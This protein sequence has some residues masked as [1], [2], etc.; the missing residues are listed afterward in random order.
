MLT[1]IMLQ[2]K[3]PQMP[4]DHSEALAGQTRAEAARE[5]ARRKEDRDREESER[6]WQELKVTAGKYVQKAQGVYGATLRNITTYRTVEDQE[7]V[8]QEYLAFWEIEFDGQK[9]AAPEIKA[10]TIEGYGKEY[11]VLPD[12]TMHRVKRNRSGAGDIRIDGE[13]SPISLIT[14]GSKKFP[15]FAG[16]EDERE[17]RIRNY[18]YY[19]SEDRGVEG[20]GT[21]EQFGT[22]TLALDFETVGINYIAHYIKEVNG[23]LKKG[24]ESAS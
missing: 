23:L 1:I 10:E 20:L 17:I 3:I 19:D 13:I 2:F 15:L 16:A 21:R 8:N 24:L 12:G 11:F 14:H 5:E 4:L 22:H 9:V 7:G 6:A 18:K